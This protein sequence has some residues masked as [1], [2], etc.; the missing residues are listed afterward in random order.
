MSQRE[1]SIFWMRYASFFLERKYC[2]DFLLVAVFSEDF[3]SLEP[4]LKYMHLASLGSITITTILLIAPSAYDRIAEQRENI[5][6]FYMFATRIVLLTLI[7]LA[8]GLS[9]NVFVVVFKATHSYSIAGYS[10]GQF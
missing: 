4:L 5:Q 9:G 6:G 3:D 10:Q 7:F 1:S 8:L 2:S